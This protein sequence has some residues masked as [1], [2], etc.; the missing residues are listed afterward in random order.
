MVGVSSLCYLPL[1]N[2]SPEKDLAPAHPAAPGKSVVKQLC[3]CIL[4]YFV[5]QFYCILH[6]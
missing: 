3:V 5:E 2:E 1:H 6:V 4:P